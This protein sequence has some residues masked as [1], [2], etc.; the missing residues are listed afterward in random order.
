MFYVLWLVCAVALGVIYHSIFDVYYVGN[1]GCIKEILWTGAFGWAAA[2]LI[3]NFFVNHPII[4]IIA[5]IVLIVLIVGLK[6]RSL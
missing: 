5:I 6:K 4:S 2:K 1:G 3:S